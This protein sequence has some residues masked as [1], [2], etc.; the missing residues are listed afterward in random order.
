MKILQIGEFGWEAVDNVG[1]S[2]FELV[3]PF[4]D[5]FLDDLVVGVGILLASVA[6][7]GDALAGEGEQ[8]GAAAFVVMVAAGADVQHGQMLELGTPLHLS[9]ACSHWERLDVTASD[10]I[11]QLVEHF[12]DH[13]AV[14]G[15]VHYS[16]IVRTVSSEALKGNT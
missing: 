8:N 3:D 9:H 14:R 2:V 15:D 11:A 16:G 6:V 1:F 12:Q 7:D 5:A 13:V 4:L 10:F